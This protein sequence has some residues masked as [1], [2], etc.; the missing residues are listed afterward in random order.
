MNFLIKKWR[1]EVRIKIKIMWEK[2]KVVCDGVKNE[3]SDKIDIFID[4]LS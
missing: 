3:W 2:T 4:K 1:N